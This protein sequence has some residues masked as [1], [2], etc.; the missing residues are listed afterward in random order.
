[1]LASMPFYVAW[2]AV[3]IVYTTGW[4]DGARVP[5]RIR[6][7][8]LDPANLL[9]L[10]GAFTATAWLYRDG[11]LAIARGATHLPHSWASFAGGA[12]LGPV[13]EEWIFRGLLWNRLRGTRPG[14]AGSVG[15]VLY[16]A[17]V[18]S[19]WHLP[20]DTPSSLVVHGA[21]GFVM[22]IL[23]WRWDSILP[24]AV[25]HSTGNALWHFT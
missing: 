17:I 13:V 18:F 9:V 4:S 7:T 15:A 10:V 25:L 21:F 24:G 12:L 20:F 16:G 14:I 8:V 6:S 11:V 19:F 22:G 1:M 3:G 5:V 23:R 2:I